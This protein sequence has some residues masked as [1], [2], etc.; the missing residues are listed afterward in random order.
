[1]NNDNYIECQIVNKKKYFKIDQQIAW[2]FVYYSEYLSNAT[3]INYPLLKPRMSAN[4]DKVLG[5]W[6]NVKS[7]HCLMFLQF[8]IS[9]LEGIYLDNGV[10]KKR[11]V[12]GYKE[13]RP[14]STTRQM[15]RQKDC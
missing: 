4:L 9:F 10:N 7:L 13:K 3:Q 14:F 1:M 11:G 2:H 8:R 15:D 12:G 5:F 6:P